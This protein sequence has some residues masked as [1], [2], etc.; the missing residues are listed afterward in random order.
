MNEKVIKIVNDYILEHLDK[1]DKEV[2]F[3]VYIVW[4]CYILGYAK[5]LVSSSLPDGMYYEVTYNK[6][7]EEFYLDAYKKFENRCI[8]NIANEEKYADTAKDCDCTDETGDWLIDDWQDKKHNRYLKRGDF[9]VYVDSLNGK[10][11]IML[12]E[13]FDYPADCA[14]RCSI[15]KSPHRMDDGFSVYGDYAPGFSKYRLAT[16]KEIFEF[17][18]AIP[19]EQWKYLNEEFKGYFA[20]HVLFYSNKR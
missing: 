9:I 20:K 2:D 5:W 1:S 18:D 16:D 10:E 12:V 11:G 19:D 13:S 3:S 8:K 4:Q 6:G 17:Y 15:G 7:K 14:A